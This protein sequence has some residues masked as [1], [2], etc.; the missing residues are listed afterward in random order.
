MNVMLASGGYPWT[1]VRVDDRTRY[2]QCLETA[3]VAMDVRPF[4]EFIAERV[5]WSTDQLKTAISGGEG[6]NE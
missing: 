1:V 3:S 6:F 2:L 5:R 4:A